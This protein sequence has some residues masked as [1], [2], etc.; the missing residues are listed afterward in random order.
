MHERFYTCQLKTHSD[1]EAHQSLHVH[2]LAFMGE[3]TYSLK[4]NHVLSDGRGPSDILRT[5][6]SRVRS[7]S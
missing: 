5:L 1:V 7:H 2:H 3:H 4:V 6:G